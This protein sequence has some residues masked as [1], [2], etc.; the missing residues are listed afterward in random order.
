MPFQCSTACADPST[1]PAGTRVTWTNHDNFTHTVRLID[2]G[3]RVVGTMSPGQSVTFT[4]S[5]PGTYRYDCSLH[6]Q[7][8]HGSV[9]VT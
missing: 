1:W 9:I 8:M 2:Q 3:N 5:R 4:F 6:P 7:D